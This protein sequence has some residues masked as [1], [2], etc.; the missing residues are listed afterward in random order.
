MKYDKG[1]LQDEIKL[2]VKQ[3]DDMSKQL[4]AISNYIP[5]HFEWWIFL[6][7]EAIILLVIYLFYVRDKRLILE[8]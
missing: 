7:G 5:V 4:E 6:P 1:N 2:L 8:Q 3:N